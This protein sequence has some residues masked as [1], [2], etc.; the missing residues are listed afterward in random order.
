MYVFLKCCAAPL[1]IL[2]GISGKSVRIAQGGLN[3][4]R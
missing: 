3:H 2:N 1:S 4:G